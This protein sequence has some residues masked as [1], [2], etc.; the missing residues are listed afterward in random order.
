[1]GDLFKAC[2]AGSVAVFK[3]PKFG[4]YSLIAHG[5]A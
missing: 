3:A 1:M 4:F 5:I 2:D